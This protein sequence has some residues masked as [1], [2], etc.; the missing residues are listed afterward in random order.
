MID[1]VKITCTLA[2]FHPDEIAALGPSFEMREKKQNEM[3][4]S[5]ETADGNS[6][7]GPPFSGEQEKRRRKARG[8]GSGCSPAEL[9][10]NKTSRGNIK[11]FQPSI[12]SDGVFFPD[13][14][15]QLH[16]GSHQTDL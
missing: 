5:I 14:F 3:A 11:L 1:D 9:P 4:A 8:T 10:T 2:A 7:R 13:T 16:P 12:L 6:A 15:L